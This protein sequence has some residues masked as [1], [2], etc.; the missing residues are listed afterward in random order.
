M[1]QYFRSGMHSHRH[2]FYGFG[3]NGQSGQATPAPGTL[4]VQVD[5]GLGASLKK[6]QWGSLAMSGGIMGLVA[7]GICRGFEVAPNKAMGIGVTMGLM[8]LVGQVA[9]Q[10]LKGWADDV[11][12]TTPKVSGW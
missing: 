9:S 3:A 7:Y 4:P 6:V 1:P 11:M 2:P 5:V 10:V 12:T 8:T